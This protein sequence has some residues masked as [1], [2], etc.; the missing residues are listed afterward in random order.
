MVKEL[1]LIYVMNFILFNYYPL[2]LLIA[3]IL[4][5]PRKNIKLF[6]Y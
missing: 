1:E 3:S 4:A 6:T 5:T 2:V